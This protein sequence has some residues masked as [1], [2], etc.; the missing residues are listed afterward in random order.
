MIKYRKNNI[1][2]ICLSIIGNWFPSQSANNEYSQFQGFS[3]FA[4]SDRWKELGAC[5]FGHL[6]LPSW[7]R[8]GSTGMTAIYCVCTIW[9]GGFH[10]Y[11]LSLFTMCI[12][13]YNLTFYNHIPIWFH[14]FGYQLTC[15]KL[16]FL[17]VSMSLNTFERWPTS[18]LKTKKASMMSIGI[19][20]LYRYV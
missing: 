10:T 14:L 16:F 8:D 19:K 15:P 20:V 7:S 13:Y 2:K 5:A 9:S 6:R 18:W 4:S 17:V 1:K 11:N 3:K 12:S